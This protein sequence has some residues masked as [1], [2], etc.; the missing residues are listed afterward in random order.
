MCGGT[1]GSRSVRSSGSLDSSPKRGSRGPR[2]LIHIVGWRT[3][4]RTRFSPPNLL[5]PDWPPLAHAA[6]LNLVSVS[7]LDRP[8]APFDAHFFWPGPLSRFLRP[9]SV[10]PSRTRLHEGDPRTGRSWRVKL[11]TEV[12]LSEP[13]GCR[14]AW[15]RMFRG[16]LNSIS[17]S[18][19]LG[20]Y[21]FHRSNSG[22]RCQT[23][24]P[25]KLSSFCEL[26]AA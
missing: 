5:S 20:R 24:L 19:L 11:A 21:P 14:R 1:N 9:R 15:R 23:A 2:G 22:S 18:D 4:S 6:F 3:R 16:I 8:V 7:P 12:G 17:P 25:V 26:I 10:P 13:L